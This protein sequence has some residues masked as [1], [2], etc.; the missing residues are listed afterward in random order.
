[1]GKPIYSFRKKVWLFYMLFLPLIMQSQTIVKMMVDQPKKLD[2][3]ADELYSFTTQSIILGENVL[4]EG[5]LAPYRY[6][7]LKDGQQIGTTLR[8]EVSQST[9]LNA[10]VL[11]VKDANNCN[12]SKN[13]IPTDLNVISENK[14]KVYPNPTTDFIIVDP[15]EM[16]GLFNLSIFDGKGIYLIRKQI[17]GKTVLDLNLPSGLYFL[18]MELKNKQM[19]FFKKLMV[20]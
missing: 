17:S 1:M 11:T 15:Q 8:L 9:P 20:L 16:D 12:C 13:A 18:K 2:I 6:F 7:W 19:V 3:I 14:I 10:V 5:G 4:V